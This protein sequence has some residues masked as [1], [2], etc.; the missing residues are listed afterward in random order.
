MKLQDQVVS[1]E[2]SKQLKEAGYPQEGIWWWIKGK[3]HMKGK[4]EL[5]LDNPSSTVGFV[6]WSKIAVAPTVAEL[7][8]ALPKRYASMI[9]DND[10]EGYQAMCWCMSNEPRDIKPMYAP[11]E[12]DARAKCWLYL[13]KENLLP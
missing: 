3:N 4:I 13:K 6:H 7:G 11:T 8:E 12:A 1:L 9:N 10:N 2:L 5:S